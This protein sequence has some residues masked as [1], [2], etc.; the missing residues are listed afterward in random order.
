[1]IEKEGMKKHDILSLLKK[2]LSRD[3]EYSKGNILGSMCTSAHT[4][5]R[6]VYCKYVNKNLGDPG[7]FPGTAELEDEIVEEIGE[8]FNGEKIFGSFTT[9]GSEANL[10]AVRIAKELRPDI[11]NPEIVL[12]I[13]AHMSFEKSADLL[14]IKLRKA[15][16]KDDFQLDTEHFKSLINENTCGI[17]GIAGT[18]SLGLVDPIHE[19]GQMI[20]NKDIFFH[21][22]A[23]FGGFVLP[24]LKDLGYSIPEWDF[25]VEQVDS[26]TADP[27][28]MGMN[29]IPS[30]AVFLKNKNII[31]KTGFE[32]PYL[33][34]GNF[35]HLH[36][37]GT[38]PGGP[39]I[40]FWALM[41]F[42][43]RRGF[44]EIIRNC[45]ENTDYLC[46]RIKEIE[47]VKLATNPVMNIVGI[48]TENGKSICELDEKL[49]NRDWMLGKFEDFNLI[50]VV[51]MPHVKQS[52][53]SE[54]AD[55]LKVVVKKLGL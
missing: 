28:K 41:K 14:G 4:F 37:V 1:M 9:G 39:V 6:E 45:M 40:S 3:Y 35:K 10:I 48:T 47:G 30:G 26:I 33:A 49:R 54:F 20:K 16:L 2:K 24:F 50:R 46:K 53:L 19:L 11:E 29:V 8:L 38:R 17:V 44:S 42:L 21:I 27:H 25:T 15:R 13:S 7:L 22:D 36:I 5:G 55:D 43:G 18:T 51:I 31:Q 23:A 32:I 52:H 34:G 12:P